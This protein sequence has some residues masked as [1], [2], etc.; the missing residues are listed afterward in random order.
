MLAQNAKANSTNLVPMWPDT[1]AFS[2]SV[3]QVSTG[4]RASFAG[5]PAPIGGS[6]WQLH[7]LTPQRL[8]DSHL[9]ASC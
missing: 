7:L 6:Q 8:A 1:P 5:R 9:E 4:L 3:A 2:P